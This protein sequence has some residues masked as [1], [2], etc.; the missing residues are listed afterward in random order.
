MLL[1]PLDMNAF[2]LAMKKDGKCHEVAD[3]NVAADRVVQFD[4]SSYVSNASQD[5]TG[6][7][8]TL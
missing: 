7:E 6:F 1:K 8:E 2:V 4:I 3:G 5:V